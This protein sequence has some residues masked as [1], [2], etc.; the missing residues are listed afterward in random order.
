MD[1][2]DLELDIDKI[3]AQARKELYEDKFK[4]AVEKEKAKI[5]AHKPLMHRIFPWKII[6]I[7]RD[8][9]S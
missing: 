4:E 8:G 5:L 3:Q 7:R 1:T 6:V 2:S 9:E